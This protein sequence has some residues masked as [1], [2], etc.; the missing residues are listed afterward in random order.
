MNNP[1]AGVNAPNSYAED[2][3]QK[4]ALVTGATGVIGPAL[5]ACLL[6]NGYQVRVF[7]RRVPPPGLFGSPVDVKIGEITDTEMVRD[8]VRGMDRVFHLAAKLHITNP[9]PALRNE[10][11]RINVEG[12]RVVAEACAEAGVERLVLFSTIAV[13]GPTKPGV[14]L[15]E[16]SDT[17][18]DS[19]YGESKRDAEAVVLGTRRRDGQPIGVVLRI[20]GTYGPRIKGNYRH[21]VHWLRRG[22]FVPIG[23]GENR[24]TL[25]HHHDVARAAV[26]AAEHPNAPGGVFNVTDGQIHTFRD[27]VYA[28]G[29][30]LGRRPTRLYIPELPARFA[31]AVV[32]RTLRL[33][34]KSAVVEPMLG[35]MLEDM[36]VSGQKIQTVLGFHP[37]FDLREGWVETIPQ[38]ND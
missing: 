8:A 24:R 3:R 30:A 35:K 26:L 10:Y 23:A 1:T 27:I 14:I 15:D 33:F 17:R 12:T 32:D 11:R 31:A 20:A 37:E 22:W 21:L 2:S 36:A 25:V 29:S 4:R 13:Y 19:L 7:T 9:D 38:I 16:D 34:G 6:E 28:I 18:A 5:V